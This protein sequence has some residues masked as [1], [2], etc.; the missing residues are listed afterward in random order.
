MLSNCL[1]NEVVVLN[2]EDSLANDIS[3]KVSDDKVISSKILD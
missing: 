1:D 3:P 2:A